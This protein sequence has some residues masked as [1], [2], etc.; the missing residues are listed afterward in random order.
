M[1]ARPQPHDWKHGRPF[2]VVAS[3]LVSLTFVALSIFPIRAADPFVVRP[4]GD[5]AG[6][7]LSNFVYD[8]W[9]N[10]AIIVL[11][12]LYFIL[13]A[14]ELPHHHRQP[15]TLTYLAILVG[16][17]ILANATWL[18]TKYSVIGVGCKA[19]CTSSGMSIVATTSMGWVMALALLAL[20]SVMLE[21][22]GGVIGRR[23]VVGCS[24]PF[25]LYLFLFLLAVEAAVVNQLPGVVFVHLFGLTFG[26]G[27][28]LVF[29]I[30]WQIRNHLT[31]RAVLDPQNYPSDPVGPE[32]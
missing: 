5:F 15:I 10:T 24:I 19:P 9:T 3:S 7:F 11:S 13:V 32:R 25:L 6:L 31:T 26:G 2:V 1:A 29:L 16:V 27:L 21:L 22:R 18:Q 8:G 14:L 30:L 4:G 20:G 28:G 23:T 17:P 12:A